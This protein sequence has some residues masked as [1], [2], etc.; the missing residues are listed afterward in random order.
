VD[1]LA[2]LVH[3]GQE[4]VRKDEGDPSVVSLR[5]VKR[6]LVLLQ[7]FHEVLPETK[8]PALKLVHSI[9]G[10]STASKL[11]GAK[12]TSTTTTNQNTNVGGTGLA[13]ATPLSRAAILAMAH[14]YCYRLYDTQSR[15]G[16]WLALSEEY[17]S[18]HAI[19]KGSASFAVVSHPAAAQ[20]VVTKAQHLIVD[21]LE[22]EA[23]VSMNQAL[24]ENLFVTI[25][26]VLNKIPIFIVGKP[27]T[28]K[29]LCMKVIASNLQGRQSARKFWQ[30]FPSIYLFQY[31]CSPLSTSD[32]IKFQYESAKSY[33]EHSQDVLTVLLLDE[34][35]LLSVYGYYGTL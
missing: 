27:G 28:S 21:N 15:E 2:R 8:P 18:M 23:G 34:V 24:T 22:V 14:V 13:Q 3:C 1:L 12:P 19:G 7:W 9:S 6:V 4:F 33:Q 17:D 30:A 20:A 11:P 31:Q 35:R 25:V 32:S 26:C 5:D 29:T 16:F 10:G